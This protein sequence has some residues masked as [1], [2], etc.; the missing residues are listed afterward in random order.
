MHHQV[1]ICGAFVCCLTAPLF[2]DGMSDT[3][4]QEAI[5][6]GKSYKNPS[7][8]WKEQ[9]EKTNKLKMSGYWSYSGSKYLSVVTDYAV[10]AMTASAAAHEMKSFSAVDAKRLP[11]LGMLRVIVA[12]SAVGADNIERIR[13]MFGSNQTHMVIEQNGAVIQPIQAVQLGG[14]YQYGPQLWKVYQIGNV[15]LANNTGAFD[16]GG[17]VYEFLYDVRRLQNGN[18][19]FTLV[20]KNNKK[21]TASVSLASLR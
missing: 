14:D 18:F 3:Q 5:E 2:A 12:I 15:V 7:K 1:L 8:L 4:I 17:V 19:Q 10:V 13:G 21:H 16:S 20:G 6:L 9:F 11:G